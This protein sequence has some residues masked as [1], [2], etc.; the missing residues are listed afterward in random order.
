M[1]LDIGEEASDRVSTRAFGEVDTDEPVGYIEP[2]IRPD[3]E[4]DRL[5]PVLLLP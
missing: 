1:A 5:H 3:M 4:I 2:Q